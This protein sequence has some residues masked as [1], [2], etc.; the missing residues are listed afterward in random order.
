M[1][2]NRRKVL[3]MLS[4]GQI[5]PDEADRLIAALE[6]ALSTPAAM[7]EDRLRAR[8]LQIVVRAEGKDESGKDGLTKVNIRV[9]VQLLRAG[10]KLAGLIPVPARKH[11][12]SALR[13][14]G[15]PFDLTEI[16]AEN[17]DELIANLDN[18]NVS[19]DDNVQV[20]IFCA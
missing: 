14:R 20:R 4:A 11:V 3:D 6:R 9:P 7:S 8:F 16:K 5:T 17:L 15:F 2:D 12:N 10:V 18:V 19:V 13:D 1:S